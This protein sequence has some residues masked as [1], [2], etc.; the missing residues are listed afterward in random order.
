M[1]ALTFVLH[2]DSSHEKENDVENQDGAVDDESVDWIGQ[3]VSHLSQR[4]AAAAVTSSFPHLGCF[5]LAAMSQVDPDKADDVER[6]EDDG[7]D[8]VQ[9]DI[10]QVADLPLDN[11]PGALR[12]QPIL[13]Q[14]LLTE[15][16]A[17]KFLQSEFDGG[18]DPGIA[19]VI[20]SNILKI[21]HQ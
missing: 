3:E 16:V 2:L 21:V 18:L 17:Y 19:R 15:V 13:S 20:N 5:F 8:A 7:G 4:V 6:Q 11:I 14:N 10:N 1:R 9:E 12:L